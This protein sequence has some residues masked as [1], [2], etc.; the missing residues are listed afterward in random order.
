MRVTLPSALFFLPV[1]LLLAGCGGSSSNSNN[2]TCGAGTHDTGNGTC[3]IDNAIAVVNGSN[4]YW[5]CTVNGSTP[6]YLQ[7][8]GSSTTSGT[9]RYQ[10]QATPTQPVYSF[11]WSEAVPSTNAM[12]VSFA[13]GPTYN[14]FTAIVPNSLVNPTGFTANL[15]SNSGGASMACTSTSG[16][17]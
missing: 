4:T 8:T 17:F 1:A 9:G 7:I 3:V 6:V 11:T 15:A 10:L 2:V 16:T 14:E 12:T 5:K 13:S